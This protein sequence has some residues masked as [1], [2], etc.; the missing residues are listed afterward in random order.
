[1]MREPH[2]PTVVEMWEAVDRMRDWGYHDDQ[3]VDLFAGW[4]AAGD[5]V[6]LW[7]NIDPASITTQPLGI[8]TPVDV[9]NN[10]VTGW[11]DH[12]PDTTWPGWRYI[13]DLVVLPPG[14]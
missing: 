11:P 10:R 3:F 9:P 8:A 14:A 4:L 6:M 12:A 2:P 7:G 13:P 1:M 5:A